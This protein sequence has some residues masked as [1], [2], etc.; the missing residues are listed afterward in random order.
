MVTDSVA[1]VTVVVCSV[2]VAVPNVIHINE[3]NHQNLIS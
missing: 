3:E 2:V 1:V